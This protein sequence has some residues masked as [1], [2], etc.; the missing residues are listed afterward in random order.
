MQNKIQKRLNEIN[1]ILDYRRKSNNPTIDKIDIDLIKERNDLQFKLNK[2]NINFRLT[3]NNKYYYANQCKIF[4]N[5]IMKNGFPYK[6]IKRIKEDGITFN[7]YSINIGYNQHCE[8]LKRFN[9]KDEL[10]GFVIG[11]NCAN[12]LN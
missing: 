12:G 6:D 7:K 9:S 3:C 10:L 1:K 5:H 11:Y 8:D 4:T 2:E